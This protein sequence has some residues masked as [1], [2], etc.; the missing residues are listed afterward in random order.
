MLS[1]PPAKCQL[2]GRFYSAYSEEPTEGCTNEEE[3]RYE[4]SYFGDGGSQPD[5]GD[6]S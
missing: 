4:A 5:G 2:S 3:A 1:G 6:G